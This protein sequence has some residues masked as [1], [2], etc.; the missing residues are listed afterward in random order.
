MAYQFNPLKYDYCK[1]QLDLRKA[2]H[3][4][5]LCSALKYYPYLFS[6]TLSPV[7]P[8]FS[9]H[10][11]KLY[12]CT[13]QLKSLCTIHRT[14]VVKLPLLRAVWAGRA[15]QG[16]ILRFVILIDFFL[17]SLAQCVPICRNFQSNV[18]KWRSNVTC[19][20]RIFFIM[21]HYINFS[22]KCS[23]LRQLALFDWKCL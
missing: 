3:F 20:E 5:H 6:F 1:S 17:R 19:I 8:E 12:L 16:S 10:I 21:R 15:G 11:G 7:W 23:L 2:M 9:L 4:P 18:V 13:V 14:I 22:V